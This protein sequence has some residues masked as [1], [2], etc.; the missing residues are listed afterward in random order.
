MA[1]MSCIMG[2]EDSDGQRLL[3]EHAAARDEYNR[4]MAAAGCA[5]PP[6]S[7]HLDQIMGMLSS[8][9]PPSIVH[10]AFDVAGT[11]ETKSTAAPTALDRFR[12]PVST[13]N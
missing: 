13:N 12:V 9:L 2:V 11:V 7:P 6:S 3:D 4:E 1:R 5:L 8:I 10:E